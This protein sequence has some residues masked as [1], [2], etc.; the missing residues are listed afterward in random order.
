MWA[1]STSDHRPWKVGAQEIGN[2]KTKEK[3]ITRSKKKKTE[4]N[5]NRNGTEQSDR[6]RPKV[7]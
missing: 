3:K 6:Q 7:N 2:A 4:G 5:S 1:A